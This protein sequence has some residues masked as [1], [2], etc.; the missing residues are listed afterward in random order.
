MCQ[1]TCFNSFLSHTWIYFGKNLKPLNLPLPSILGALRRL[2]LLSLLVTWEERTAREDSQHS[3]R[4]TSRKSQ[5]PQGV[6]SK[7]QCSLRERCAQLSP[8]LGTL[9]SRS[10][11]VGWESKDLERMGQ[12]I[13]PPDT[14][15]PLLFPSLECLQGCPTILTEGAVGDTTLLTVTADNSR[16]E[17][18][19][20]TQ[21]EHL[22]VDAYSLRRHLTMEGVVIR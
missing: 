1:V 13:F 6:S 18:Q 2:S 8:A 4:H 5:S 14:L 22:P 10:M 9:T 12:S 16:C 11:T 3:T 20:K 21:M 7:R 15:H 19:H 17:P